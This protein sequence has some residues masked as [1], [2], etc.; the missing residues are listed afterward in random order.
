MAKYIA[1]L[2]AVNVGGR[3]LAMAD[4][5]ETLAK[6]GFADA[7][8]L[9]QSGNVV[10]S[11]DKRSNDELEKL[12]EAGTEKRHKMQVDFMVRSA[13][14]WAGIVAAN[15]Y[16]KE[17]RDDPARLVVVA[18]KLPAKAGAEKALQAAIKGRET[19]RVFGR[20]AYMYYPDG[21]GTSKVTPAIVERHL[22][23][24]GTA[25]NWNTVLKLLALTQ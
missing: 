20:N 10:F 2:R 11:S 1:L 23:A 12:L 18:L 24:R 17:A 25:R 9:L 13:K 7:K 5:R 4:L 22:G 15:P 19:V 16:P 8:T 21:Q 14:E 3:S 6:L